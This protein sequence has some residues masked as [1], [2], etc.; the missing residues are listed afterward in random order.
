MD[1]LSSKTNNSLYKG[2]FW[3]KDTENIESTT[4]CY[5]LECDSNGFIDVSDVN[6]DTLGKLRNNFN[7]KKLWD[8]LPADVTENK[9]F[10]YYPR[11][12]VE[13]NKGKATIFITQYLVE[14]KDKV[15]EFIENKF[16]LIELNGIN[17]VK[18][19]VDGSDHYKAKI[20]DI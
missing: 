7:H 5:M 16:G 11:G 17:E 15:V 19:F 1:E 12:R 10:D 18:I 20:E 4:L 13:I 3:I 2:V 6:I 14:Y 8:T 9:Q